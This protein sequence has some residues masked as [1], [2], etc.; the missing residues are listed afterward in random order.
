LREPVFASGDEGSRAKAQRFPESIQ[1]VWLSLL[2][3]VALLQKV[4]LQKSGFLTD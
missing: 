4:M 2:Q 3:K 1:K